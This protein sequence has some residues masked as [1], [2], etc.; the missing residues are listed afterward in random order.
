MMAIKYLDDGRIA[1]EFEIGSAPH[2]LN[3][4]IVMR[5]EDYAQY[6][7]TE[8]AAMKQQRYDNWIAIIMAPQPEMSADDTVI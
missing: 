2:I 7:A 6:S 4:A 3:D 8:I 5:P 1:D